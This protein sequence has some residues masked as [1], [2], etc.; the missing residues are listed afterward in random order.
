MITFN[1]E[2]MLHSRMRGEHEDGDEDDEYVYGVGDATKLSGTTST[3]TITCIEVPPKLTRSN[4]QKE[5]QLW[6]NT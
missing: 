3:A 5:Y 2:M 6:R 1:V 4:A